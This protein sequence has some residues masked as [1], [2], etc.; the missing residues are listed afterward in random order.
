[1]TAHVLPKCSYKGVRKYTNDPETFSASVLVLCV[2]SMAS[3]NLLPLQHLCQVWA[4]Q[5]DPERGKARASKCYSSSHKCGIKQRSQRE[6]TF[7]QAWSTR[8]IICLSFS[9]YIN[10]SSNI[11]NISSFMS[12]F[13][14]P[15][16]TPPY[17]SSLYMASFE[18][19]FIVTDIKVIA[20]EAFKLFHFN[21]T[22]HIAVLTPKKPIILLVK[23]ISISS[24]T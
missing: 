8:L 23:Y 12:F 17:S 2:R 3:T 19:L 10:S 20:L 1:M 6:A 14:C 24:W 4:N 5:T 22:V 21:N 11:I 16:L 18:T 9:L 13:H 7:Q 15:A